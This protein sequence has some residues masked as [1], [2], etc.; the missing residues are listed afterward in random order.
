MLKFHFTTVLDCP[1]LTL[2]PHSLT[3]CLPLSVS[4]PL[5]LCPCPVRLCSREISVDCFQCHFYF[6]HSWE[7]H[8][9]PDLLHSPRCLIWILFRYRRRDQLLSL[10]HP[11]W[12]HLVCLRLPQLHLHC[13][14]PAARQ[15]RQ[16]SAS[17]L[18]QRQRHD[19]LHPAHHH[20][21]EGGA[22]F[23]L[24]LC[25]CLSLSLNLF[26]TSIRHCL[27]DLSFAV[28]VLY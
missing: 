17:L 1:L 14:S 21:R 22:S 7:D 12:C 19:P 28:L 24:S 16:V 2:R 15:R 3:L 13:Q 20:L 5:P 23:S 11:R 25:L 4:L 6:S 18:Q 10:R 9:S 27:T 8:L 26:I